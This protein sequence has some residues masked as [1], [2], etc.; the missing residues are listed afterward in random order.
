MSVTFTLAS[1]AIIAGI[2]LSSTTTLAVISGINDGTVNESEG[3][4]TMF[5]DCALLQETL[6]AHSCG[7]K[8]LSENE[9]IVQTDCGNMRYVRQNAAE[10][11]KL[12]LG[13]ISNPEK[14][15]DNLKLFEVDYGRNVQAYTYNHV[16][17]NMTD[18]MA[19]QNEEILED[20]TIVLTINVE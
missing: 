16:R 18:G 6:L 13:D 20:D 12:E 15:F 1:A 3:I 10:A 11:F 9:I 2:T 14:F 8:V 4:E 7:V 19:V 5:N 17:E